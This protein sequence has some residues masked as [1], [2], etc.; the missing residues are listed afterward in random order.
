MAWGG[1]A[2]HGPA[3]C[4]LNGM[5]IAFFAAL[6]ALKEFTREDIS[7]FLDLINPGKMIS[8]MGDEMKNQ[9]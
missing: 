6:A 8:Y 9:K 1:T 4:P 2:L 5:Q 3:K 7:Y